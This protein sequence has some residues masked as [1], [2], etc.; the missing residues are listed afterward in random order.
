MKN[1]QLEPQKIEDLIS[2]AYKL[3]EKQLKTLQQYMVENKV[4]KLFTFNVNEIAEEDMQ[5]GCDDFYLLPVFTSVDKYSNYDEFAVVSVGLSAKGELQLNGEPKT[6][7]A[8]YRVLTGIDNIIMCTSVSDI[9]DIL[10]LVREN[11]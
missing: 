5:T 9:A 8:N 10:M 11:N 2:E 3:A 4:S 1:I 7:G 6:E